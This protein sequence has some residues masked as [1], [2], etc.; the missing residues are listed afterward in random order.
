[1]QHEGTDERLFLIGRS[2]DWLRW[3]PTCQEISGGIDELLRREGSWTERQQVV[4]LPDQLAPFPPL[5]R[6]GCLRRHLPREVR[7]RPVPAPNLGR[8]LTE[9][10]FLG[11]DDLLPL[12]SEADLLKLDRRVAP[13]RRRADRAHDPLVVRCVE[14]LASA[15]TWLQ[16]AELAELERVSERTITRRFVADLGCT[17]RD[18]VQA[19]RADLRDYLLLAGI[20]S[21]RVAS[22][23]GYRNS[24]SLRM[25]VRREKGLGMREWTSR[26]QDRSHPR[27][28]AQCFA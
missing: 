18:H 9:L 24:T 11:I 10:W 4:L 13:L 28:D 25:A 23:V 19:L 17:V 14:R 6:I 7:L 1:M 8:A 20:P 5:E 12:S 16:V 2:P 27:P 22:L 26:L 3:H 21:T 15:R